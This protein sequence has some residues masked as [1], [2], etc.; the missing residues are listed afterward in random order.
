MGARARKQEARQLAV[1]TKAKKA[2]AAAIRKEIKAKQAAAAKKNKLADERR[3]KVVL[4]INKH[5][6]ILSHLGRISAKLASEQ[7]HMDATAP[8]ASKEGAYKAK[9]QA[10]IKAAADAVGIQKAAMKRAADLAKQAAAAQKVVKKDVIIAKKKHALQRKAIAESKKSDHAFRLHV[11]FTKKHA[12][13][14]I[15]HAK[16]TKKSEAAAKKVTLSKEVAVNAMESAQCV[17]KDKRSGCTKWKKT[18]HCKTA[19][20]KAWMVTHC[21]ES[22]GFSCTDLHELAMGKMRNE[23]TACKKEESYS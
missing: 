20:F 12:A 8:L 18:G 4:N 7:A 19:S 15:L 17:I 9:K 2:K 22:C 10:S 23:K 13:T 3:H 1:E 5:K 16:W 6:K 11:K 21:T 14:T